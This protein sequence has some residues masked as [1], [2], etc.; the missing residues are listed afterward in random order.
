MAGDV[1]E[2]A[3][4]A[5]RDPSAPIQIVRV[6]A[7]P[8]RVEET[9]RWEGER[10]AERGYLYR[11]LSVSEATHAKPPLSKAH[12]LIVGGG[13][14]DAE[15]L[16]GLESLRLI[17]SCSVGTD[18]IDLEAASRN[19]IR[20]CY[21]PDL[22]TD[23]VA[24]HTLALI[25]ACVR[26]V[27]FLDRRIRAHCWD[28]ELLE[29]MPRLRGKTLGLVG[30]GRIAVAVATRARAFGLTVLAS[31]PNVQEA[32]VPL[33]ALDELFELSHIISCHTPL[34][35]ATARLIGRDQFRRMQ[36]GGYFINTSRGAVVDED[37]LF[38]A[39]RD[40]QLLAVGLD[41][42]TEEPPAPDHPLLHLPNV[43]NTPH[44]GGFSDEVVESIPRRAVDEVIAF[45]EGTGPNPSVTANPAFLSGSTG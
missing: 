40:G 5:Q 31:D 2:A 3:S 11:A 28:R 18:W 13:N 35:S 17:V 21:M 4:V 38:E 45:F 33:V 42:L 39:I 26:K 14:W 24:D 36:P 10:F 19:G 7:Y 22:C 32:D 29:P 44:A 23:E 34:T 25:L 8:H 9:T 20:V 30:Y 16:A 37:A 6:G 43:V 41:V 12:G 1:A 27:S 15:I